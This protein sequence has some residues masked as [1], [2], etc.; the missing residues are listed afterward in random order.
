MNY[1]FSPYFFLG[2][3]KRLKYSLLYWE[4]CNRLILL[5]TYFRELNFAFCL[6]TS[7]LYSTKTTLKT[8]KLPIWNC[9][10]NHSSFYHI[11]SRCNIFQVTKSVLYHCLL[12]FETMIAEIKY[13]NFN[14]SYNLWQMLYYLNLFNIL[15]I[16]CPTFLFNTVYSLT[17]LWE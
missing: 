1:S 13:Q 12:S 9:C 16:D 4:S 10:K 17:K 3:K 5:H 11:D 2:S 6:P 8:M 15:H 14:I 7:P